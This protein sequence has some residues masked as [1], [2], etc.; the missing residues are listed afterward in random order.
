MKDALSIHRLLLEHQTPHEIVRL[1]HPITSADELPEVLGLPARRCLCTRLYADDRGL[2]TH[3]TP[4]SCRIAAI[5]VTAGMWPCAEAV[6]GAL[7]VVEVSPASADLVN[8]ATDYAADLV[9]PLMLPD[10]IAVLV[11][12][13]ATRPSE[14]VYTATGEGSTALGIHTLDLFAL[15]AAEP[16][17][18]PPT[19]GP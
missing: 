4:E 15:C 17:P 8:A 6:A 13:R 5:I 11:D 16:V 12:E 18:G 2:R 7:D 3:R 1:R 9:A 10:G 14:V 19:R